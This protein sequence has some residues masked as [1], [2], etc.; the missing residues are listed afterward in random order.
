MYEIVK[1]VKPNTELVVYYDE[2][3][4]H[5]RLMTKASKMVQHELGLSEHIFSNQ[6]NIAK[7]TPEQYKYTMNAIIEGWCT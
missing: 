5:H 2:S 3:G 7:M 4:A 6:E 1:N